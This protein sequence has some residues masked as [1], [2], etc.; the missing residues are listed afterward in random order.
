LVFLASLIGLYVYTQ[1]QPQKI[2]EF[3]WCPNQA[4]QDINT[5][6]TNSLNGL[7]NSLVNIETRLIN[8]ETTINTNNN[9]LPPIQW[10]LFEPD[11][12][13]EPIH[14]SADGTNAQ[15]GD[16]FIGISEQEVP[17]LPLPPQ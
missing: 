2:R 13:A 12:Q 7:Q 3:L 10:P 4:Q 16:N 17:G 8:R 1:K 11:T 5:Q 9:I 15:A 14:W 6:I